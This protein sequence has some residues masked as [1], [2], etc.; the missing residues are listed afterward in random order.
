MEIMESY[1]NWSLESLLGRGT[2]TCVPVEDF[3]V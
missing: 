2:N 1:G 3:G